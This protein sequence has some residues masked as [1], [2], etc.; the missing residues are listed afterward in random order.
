M[1]NKDPW[2]ILLKQKES[3]G[4][5]LFNSGG[6]ASD[7]N[8]EWVRGEL[9]SRQALNLPDETKGLFLPFGFSY[10]LCLSLSF[11]HGFC[12]RCG[13]KL[14]RKSWLLWV[15]QSS[16]GADR[17]RE[18]LPKVFSPQKTFLCPMAVDFGLRLSRCPNVKGF[19]LTLNEQ[20][21]INV[22]LFVCFS[23]SC[24]FCFYLFLFVL[25]LL[26]NL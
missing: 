24:V 10:R 17:R 2:Q 26:L 6:L 9:T 5:R 22:F 23:F 7:L 8:Q 3:W 25:F 19:I 12:V 15:S 11:H 13:Q 14:L 4:V 20:H 18:G 21:Q 1:F 16:Q